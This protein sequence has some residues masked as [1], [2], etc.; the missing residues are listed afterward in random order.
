M[1]IDICIY[2]HPHGFYE[3]LEV[4]KDKEMDY[5]A[6]LG[7]FGQ[8]EEAFYY[9]KLKGLHFIGDYNAWVKARLM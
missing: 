3:V 4:L 7:V 2:P 9:A 5:L 1:K 8:E 6:T